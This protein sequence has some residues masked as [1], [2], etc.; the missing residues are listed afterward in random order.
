[1]KKII[2]IILIS[3]T[4]TGCTDN[5]NNILK[6]TWTATPNNQNIYQTKEELTKHT[7]NYILTCDEKG[8]FTLKIENNNTIKGYY[9]ASKNNNVTFINDG[10]SIL[11]ECKLIDNKELDCKEKSTYAFKY[12]KN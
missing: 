12:T 7:E 3:I 11:A 6:G 4:I 2:N 5:K 10:N 8:T 1:M 9:T